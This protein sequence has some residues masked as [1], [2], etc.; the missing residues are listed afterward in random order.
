MSDLLLIP[1]CI[2]TGM[3]LI[4]HKAFSENSPKII[5][6][7]I[8]YICLPAL[9]LYYVPQIDVSY[10][11]IFPA[12]VIWII[13][14]LSA[15]F[16]ILLQKIFKWDRK[17][18]GALILTG[19]LANTS[20]VGFPVLIALFGE[21]GLKIGVIIDQAGSF[22]VLSTLGIIAASIYSSGTYSIKKIINNI[23][24]YPSFIAFVVSLIMIAAGVRHNDFSS[25]ILMQLG[26]PTIILALISVGMQLN[27]KIDTL[28]W[29]EL[30][31]GLMYKLVLAPAVIFV[32][33]YYFFRLNGLPFQVSLIE[34][35][36]P[37]MVMGSVLATQ[38]NLNPKLANLMIGIGIPI[39]AITLA[40]WWMI[41]R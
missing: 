40:L 35:A 41:I 32:L 33:Y 21:A 3:L 27:P 34:S 24:T 1:L 10:D 25:S 5:N 30:I 9:T 20:F 14:I 19:G 29:K 4:R 36:M 11:L 15:A 8:I 18:T 17:T 13:F 28:L 31:S 39:S 38:F 7:L 26:R 6:S 12:V 16:F 23:L 37:P 22:L 2:L